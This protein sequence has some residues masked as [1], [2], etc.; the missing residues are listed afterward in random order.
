[1]CRVLNWNF[2]PNSDGSSVNGY[3]HSNVI[4]ETSFPLFHKNW[5]LQSILCFFSPKFISAVGPYSTHTKQA[6][7]VLYLFERGRGHLMVFYLL[8]LRAP[9]LI[10]PSW[11]KG[12]SFIFW[13]LNTREGRRLLEISSLFF[14]GRGSI[15]C[16][17]SSL[18]QRK[19]KIWALPPSTAPV[20]WYEGGDTALLW[21][22][23]KVI[24]ISQPKKWFRLTDFSFPFPKSNLDWMSESSWKQ[25][26]SLIKFHLKNNEKASS[27]CLLF[28]E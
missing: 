27:S 5:L 11:D 24:N 4:W 15:S 8:F 26:L 6:F 9:T 1:M 13:K 10:R 7:P 25:E 18:Q 14:A 19:R 17:W 28:L 20:T 2:C 22:T 23:L 16:V 12:S 21:N 3:R